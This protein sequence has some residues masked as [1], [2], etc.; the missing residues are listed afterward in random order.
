MARDPEPGPPSPS[1]A[2]DLIQR[3]ARV[4]RSAVSRVA[5]RRAHAVADDIVQVVTLNL[6]RHLEREQVIES[7]SSYIYKAAIREAVRAM[8]REH[9]RAEAGLDEAQGVAASSAD[10][11]DQ[12]ALRQ[13]GAAIDDEI[14]A[15]P[16]DRQAAVC[17]H[18]AGF[19][20]AE[21]MRLHGWPYQRARNLVARGM[22]DLRTALRA[23]GM[24]P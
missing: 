9:K 19:D 7:P 14:R 2:A 15:L 12:A 6:W 8:R 23:R 24:H 3:Y 21:I 17:A 16:A 10:P 22:H 4:I 1:S 13:L 11:H 20:V 18:L 5:G